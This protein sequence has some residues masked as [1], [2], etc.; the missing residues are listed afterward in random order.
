[1][2]VTPP[3]VSV[4]PSPSKLW[5]P[6]GKMI[7]VTVS[8]TIT[9]SGL[10][11]DRTTATFSVLDE[12]GSVQPSGPVSLGSDGTYSFT[13]LLQASRQAGDMDGRQYTI[14]VSVK[15]LAGNPGSAS[16]IVTVPH[17]QGQ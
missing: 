5:P 10:G 1:M 6:N 11:I 7:S 3:A 2:Q 16:T 8:G 15:D 4:S 17:D 9:D 13:I 12:Y 14:R